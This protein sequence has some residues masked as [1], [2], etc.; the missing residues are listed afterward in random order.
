MYDFEQRMV[1]RRWRFNALF[2]S[3]VYKDVG[4]VGIWYGIAIMVVPHAEA[5]ARILLLVLFSIFV[6]LG[7]KLIKI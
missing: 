5:S 7:I 1:A 3:Q 4:V 2:K 6:W